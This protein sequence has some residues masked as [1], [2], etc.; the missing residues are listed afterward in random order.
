MGIPL[1]MARSDIGA[2]SIRLSTDESDRW[3]FEGQVSPKLDGC[4]E[5]DLGSSASTRPS[6]APDGAALPGPSF[7][8]SLQ[9]LRPCRDHKPN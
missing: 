5:V 7:A 6:S 4:L 8:P 2:Q 3:Q 9:R 1:V